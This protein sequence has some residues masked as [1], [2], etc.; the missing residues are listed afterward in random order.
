M[1][2]VFSKQQWK[3]NIENKSARLIKTI[4]K[5][6]SVKSELCLGVFK[7][8]S[9]DCFVD[10]LVIFLQCLGSNFLN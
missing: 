6:S 5:T 8:F 10:I 2:R 9:L 4:F 7:H 3:H 1:F